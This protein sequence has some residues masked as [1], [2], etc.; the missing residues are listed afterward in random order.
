MALYNDA[1]AILSIDSKQGSLKS[2]IYGSTTIKSK[3]AQLFALIAET[4]KRDV[5]LKEV[6]D[7]ARILD[8]EPKV[9]LVPEYYRV[10]AD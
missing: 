8:E 4:S 6:I 10:I 3:P 2:Q 7:N 1:A 5:F 9:G